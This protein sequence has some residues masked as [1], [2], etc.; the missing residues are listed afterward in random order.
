MSKQTALIVSEIGGRVKATSD[1]PIP[2]PGDK[3]V[4]IRVTVAALNPHDQKSRDGGLFTKDF[5][6]AVLGNDVTGVVTSVG[7]A[8][9]SS[10][11]VIGL[12]HSHT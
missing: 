9:P 5:L 6:P 1:W 8:L 11:L 2:Q 4:Q 3:Q 10:R 7:P 12:S